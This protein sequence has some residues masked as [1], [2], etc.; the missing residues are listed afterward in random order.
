MKIP[1]PPHFSAEDFPQEYRS[2][3]AKMIG[4]LNQF[5]SAVYSALNASLSVKDNLNA[6]VKS[7]TFEGRPVTIATNLKSKPIGVLI[8]KSNPAAP[9][10]LEWSHS[11]KTVTVHNV[12]GL[13]RKKFELTVLIIAE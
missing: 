2:W 6:E 4:P 1:Q 8:L 12:E 13:P 10:A 5:L 9:V 7:F 11:G 3:I